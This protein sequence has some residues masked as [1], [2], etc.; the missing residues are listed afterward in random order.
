MCRSQRTLMG[1]VCWTGHQPATCRTISSGPSILGLL[2]ALLTG[3]PSA[4]NLL[5]RHPYVTWRYNIRYT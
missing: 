1:S 3:Q 4:E 2:T 5:R